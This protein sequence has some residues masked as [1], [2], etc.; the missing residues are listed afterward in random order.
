MTS[1]Q[2]GVIRARISHSQIKIIEGKVIY[3]RYRISLRKPVLGRFWPMA[4]T[5][6]WP[7]VRCSK[8]VFIL[9]LL[10]L[11]MKHVSFPSKIILKCILLRISNFFFWGGECNVSKWWPSVNTTFGQSLSSIFFPSSLF[12]AAPAQLKGCKSY[13]FRGLSRWLFVTSHPAITVGQ[14]N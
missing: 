14:H 1:S 4:E 9:F 8:W 6:R 12:T 5:R 2:N 7:T 13:I 3:S 10:R 11:S